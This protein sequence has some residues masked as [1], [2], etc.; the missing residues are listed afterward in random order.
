[1]SEYADLEAAI[2]ALQDEAR[3]RKAD[4]RMAMSL[5][6]RKEQ[7]LRQMKAK[8]AQLEDEIARLRKRQK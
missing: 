7:E 8:I 2:V 1:M 6:P 3:Q 5:A 4:E